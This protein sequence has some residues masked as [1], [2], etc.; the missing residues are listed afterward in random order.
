[1]L[2][3]RY[4]PIFPLHHAFAFLLIFV[5]LLKRKIIEIECQVHCSSSC[6]VAVCCFEMCLTL[7][8][9]SCFHARTHSVC[10]RLK[11]LLCFLFS[12]FVGVCVLGGAALMSKL[13]THVKPESNGLGYS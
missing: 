11:L 10:T 12:L 1:M 5:S 4:V 8:I 9:C 6:S 7:F 13:F 2:M 3:V